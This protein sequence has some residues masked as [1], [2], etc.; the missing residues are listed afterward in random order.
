MKEITAEGAT[1]VYFTKEDALMGN[2]RIDAETD[3]WLLPFM[4]NQLARVEDVRPIYI[5]SPFPTSSERIQYLHWDDGSDLVALDYKVECGTFA[6]VDFESSILTYYN[7]TLC[8]SC[9]SVWHTLVV[10]SPEWLYFNTP[11]LYQKKFSRR[12]AVK[13]P[14]CGEWFRIMVV[15]IFGQAK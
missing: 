11:G 7:E 14:I 15:K 1:F 4:E 13:C 10:N 2:W 3:P 8:I 9:Q 12:K 6:D 5:R